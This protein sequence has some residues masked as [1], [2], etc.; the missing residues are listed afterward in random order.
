MA[1]QDEK[2]Q[3][4]FSMIELWKASGESQQA[5][6]KGQG[7]AYSGFH[8]WLKR[9]R[10]VQVNDK[11]SDFVKLNFPVRDGGSPVAEL[12]MPDGRLLRFYQGVDA[13]L[14]RALLI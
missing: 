12:V 6:C 13:S 14:L 5:F 10:A 1:S 11:P 3:K 8:Y 9:Y 2:Q 7:M 4:M